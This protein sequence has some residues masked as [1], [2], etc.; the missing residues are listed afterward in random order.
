MSLIREKIE[1]MINS[2]WAKAISSAKNFE[3]YGSQMEF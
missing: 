3:G 1:F 2:Y